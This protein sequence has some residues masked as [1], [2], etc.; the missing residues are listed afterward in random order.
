VGNS[1]Q[2]VHVGEVQCEGGKLRCA[3]SAMSAGR[4]TA[5]RH[6]QQGGSFAHAPVAVTFGILRKELLVGKR[7]KKRKRRAKA[8]ERERLASMQLSTG[9]SEGMSG[10]MALTS[11]GSSGS[12]SFT[13]RPSGSANTKAPR[14]RP[15]RHSSRPTTRILSPSHRHL[16]KRPDLWWW[17]MILISTGA[18]VLLVQWMFW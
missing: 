16:R 4:F 8:N 9:P 7:G 10:V 15:T 13:R 14:S 12:E 18:C 2:R 17:I 11:Q 5:V 6:P 3:P 1:V